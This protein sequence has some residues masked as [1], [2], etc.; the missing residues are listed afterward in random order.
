MATPGL[1]TGNVVGST[2][3]AATPQAE[4]YK[5]GQ[6]EKEEQRRWDRQEEI[7]LEAEAAAKAAQQKADADAQM[8]SAFEK[9]YGPR[10]QSKW[11]IQSGQTG[12]LQPSSGLVSGTPQPGYALYKKGGKDYAQSGA[13]IGYGQQPYEYRPDTNM[14]GGYYQQQLDAAYE[15]WKAGKLMGADKY[16]QAGYFGGGGGGGGSTAAGSTYSGAAGAT[17]PQGYRGSPYGY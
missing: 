17:I 3:Q 11:D 9:F 7:R 16:K 1:V 6:L 13:G 12:G 2:Y 4:S 5:Y 8:K 14:P 15:M 10:A